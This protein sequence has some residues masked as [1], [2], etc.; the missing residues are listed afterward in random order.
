MSDTVVTAI[1][2]M[3]LPVGTGLCFFVGLLI[4]NAILDSSAKLVRQIDSVNLLLVSHLASDVEKHNA[5]DAHLKFSDDRLDR[6]EKKVF[7]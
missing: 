1:V 6:L 4:R 3:L 7:V 2:A 5:L